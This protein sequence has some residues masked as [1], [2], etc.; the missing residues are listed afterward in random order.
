PTSM[1]DASSR[2]G[3]LNLLMELRNAYG[4]SIMF[5][6]H[7]IGLAYYTSDRLFIMNSGKI[8]EE[9]DAEEIINN[10]KDTYTKKLLEDVPVIHRKWEL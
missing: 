3:I 7:D 6:T 2:A 4:M 9:G 1:I 8:V 10:P 5:I